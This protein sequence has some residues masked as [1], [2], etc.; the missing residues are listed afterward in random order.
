[1]VYD[2]SIPRINNVRWLARL[3]MPFPTTAGAIMEIAQAWRF[4]K[5]TLDFL[6]LFPP[7]LSFES[8]EDFM[9]RCEEVELLLREEAETPAEPIL[10]PQD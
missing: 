7:D 1:M 10:S 9:T 8:R 2:N 6:E 3:A 5:S 4:D